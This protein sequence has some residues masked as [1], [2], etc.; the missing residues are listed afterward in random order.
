MEPDWNWRCI[1]LRRSSGRNSRIYKVRSDGR[2]FALKQY[3]SRAEDPRDRLP[4][5]VG[6][7]KQYE[8]VPW[9][10]VYAAVRSVLVPPLEPS[11]NP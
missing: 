3:P 11:H 1:S 2:T 6:A 9:E 10:L 7:W 4:T 8:D 5:E